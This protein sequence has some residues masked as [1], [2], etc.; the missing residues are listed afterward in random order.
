MP[1]EDIKLIRE[2]LVDL[3]LDIKIRKNSEVIK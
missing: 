2:E 1:D 3:Y